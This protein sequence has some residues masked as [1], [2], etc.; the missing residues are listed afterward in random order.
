MSHQSTLPFEKIQKSHFNL[1]LVYGNP[2]NTMFYRLFAYPLSKF[3]AI[4]KELIVSKVKT[5]IQIILECN[6]PQMLILV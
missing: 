4:A 1:I 5:F 3:V 2:I 6:L